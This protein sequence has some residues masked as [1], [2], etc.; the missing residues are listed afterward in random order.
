MI[1]KNK[2]RCFL[3]IDGVINNDKTMPIRMDITKEEIY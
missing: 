3:D 1:N 2:K